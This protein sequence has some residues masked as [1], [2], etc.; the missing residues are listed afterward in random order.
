MAISD[1]LDRTYVLDKGLGRLRRETKVCWDWHV[2][3]VFATSHR[4]TCS[5]IWLA[6]APGT[7]VEHLP[8]RRPQ[9]RRPTGCSTSSMRCVGLS[10]SRR[11]MRMSAGSLSTDLTLQML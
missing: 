2:A 5:A 10:F 4:R 9:Y 1:T 6:V 3:Q 11:L 7:L 8:C